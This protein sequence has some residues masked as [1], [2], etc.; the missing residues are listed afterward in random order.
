MIQIWHNPRCRKSRETLDLLRESG[1]D[2]EI[3][4]YLNQGPGYDELKD[5]LKK[6][7]LKPY[8]LLRRNEKIFKEKYKGQDLSDED[9]I[10]TMVKNPILIERP[11]V[12]R[13]D[14]AAIGRPPENIYPIL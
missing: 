11:I 13:G 12:I 14:L 8:D 9:W 6:L 5:V 3:R 2:F 7:G 4:E 1:K 10:M